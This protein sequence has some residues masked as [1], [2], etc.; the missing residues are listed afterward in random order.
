MNKSNDSIR[1]KALAGVVILGIAAITTVGV[2][3]IGK[4]GT[5]E[6]P[7]PLVDLNS[8]ETPDLAD[9]GDGNTNVAGNFP[10]VTASPDEGQAGQVADGSDQ[11]N[12]PDDTQVAD[13]QEASAGDETQ[14]ADGGDES[15]GSEQPGDTTPVQSAEVNGGTQVAEGPEQGTSLP[16][17]TEKEPDDTATVLSPQVIAESLNYQKES[18]LLWPIRGEVLIPYSPDHGVFH[19]TLEQFR[20][21]NAVVL[22]SEVGTPVF[23]AAKG[24]VVSITDNV[25]T[26]KTV[27]L[28]LGNDIYLVYGQLALDGLEVGDVV[29]EGDCIGAVAAPTRYYVIEGP[30]LYFQVLEGEEPINPMLLLHGEEDVMAE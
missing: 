15:D 19:Y 6:T 11:T 16:E 5:E 12:L 14:V 23:A 9:G 25:R 30:N 20:T 3:S 17:K 24:V 27:K 1:K 2:L 26:G 21:S 22:S 4:N 29:K 28:A 7:D 13:G 8:P 10:D 18:G